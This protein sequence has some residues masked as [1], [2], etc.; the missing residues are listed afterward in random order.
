MRRHAVLS[1]L[2]LGV[3]AVLAAGSAACAGAPP[4]P[5]APSNDLM[6]EPQAQIDRDGIEVAAIKG[7]EPVNPAGD[8]NATC[9]PLAIAV[10]GELEGPDALGADIKDGVQLAVDQ[11]NAANPA[12]QVQ[13]KAFDTEGDPTAGAALAGRIVEDAQIVGVVGPATSDEVLA[14]GT[15]FDRA[16]LVAVTPSAGR[17]A[18]S[19]RGWRTLLRGVAGD[20]VQG[21]AVANYLTRSLGHRKVCVVD[22][23]SGH[24]LG[25]ATVV[26]ETLGAMADSACNIAVRS[27]DTDFSEVVTQI[28]SAAPDSVFFAGRHPQAVPL[29]SQLRDGGFGGVIVGADGSNGA[30][31]I[32]QAGSAAEGVVLSCPCSPAPP[33]F[34]TEYTREFNR[35]P[36]A[37]SV[38][39]Y[40]LA[41][42]LL[43]G[44]DSGAV[45]RPELLDFVRDY[46]GQ[47]IAHRYQWT[48]DGDLEE[49]LIW[50]YRVAG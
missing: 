29:V 20:E 7:T 10:V 48:R 4:V 18:L 31:F 45:A 37:Y 14:I 34:V 5:E 33:D 38:E 8:G 22:D 19:Q 16:G 35:P 41:T 13:L 50:I 39:A 25:L 15:A 27:D 6:I 3:S 11:H 36:G 44:I 40:D 46:D 49:P 9:P 30:A 12:C 47:G 32:E 43:V 2:A 42:I 1:M 24:G 17:P 21:T 26:R 23:G 28:N